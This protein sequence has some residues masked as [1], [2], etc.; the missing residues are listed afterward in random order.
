MFSHDTVLSEAC[1][2]NMC[3]VINPCVP[4]SVLK[5]NSRETTHHNSIL[6]EYTHVEN[7]PIHTNSSRRSY[8][9]GSNLSEE[10][11]L[12]CFRGIVFSGNSIFEYLDFEGFVV[13]I[14]PG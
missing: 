1:P 12:N 14:I 9:E 2:E 5:I 6:C 13:E 3:F 10:D 11:K 8:L 7:E 4:K